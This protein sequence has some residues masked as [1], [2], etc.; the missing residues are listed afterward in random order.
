MKDIVDLTVA[1]IRVFAVDVIPFRALRTQ[2]VLGR[3]KQQLGFA[4]VMLDPVAPAIGFQGGKIE[5]DG[6]GF[7]IEGLAIEPRRMQLQVL[8]PSRVAD[9]CYAAV[10]EVIAGCDREGSTKADPIVTSQ[11]TSCSVTLAFHVERLFAKQVLSFAREDLLP[12]A[13]LPGSKA[14]VRSLKLEVGIGYSVQDQRIKDHD[15]SLSPKQL[16][17][18]PRVGTR[19]EEQRYFTSSPLDSE[20]HLTVLEMLETRLKQTK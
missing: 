18:E 3:F 10:R 17:I 16:V 2:E 19:L 15:I 14:I 13:A 1:Q 7:V 8:G 9:A 12:R 6:Q 11:E 20:A 4:Q 5:V